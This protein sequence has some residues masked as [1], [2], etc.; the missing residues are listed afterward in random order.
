MPLLLA[1]ARWPGILDDYR[2]DREKEKQDLNV[3]QV[4]SDGARPSIEYYVLTV[5]SC[6]IATAGLITGSTAVIIGAMIVAPLMTP[7]LAFS[8]AVV[9]GDLALVRGSLFSLARGVVLAVGISALISVLVPIA[10]PS[11]EIIS[12]T[13]PTLY[14]IIVALVAGVLGAY[15][16]ANRK[17]NSAVVGIAI[18][19]AL[20]PPLCTV[21]IELGKG[22]YSSAA[23]ASLLFAINLVSISLA[24]SVVFLVMKI[25]PRSEADGGAKRRALYQIVLS[26]AVLVAI[27]IPV[28]AYVRTGYILEQSRQAAA[29]ILTATLPGSRVFSSEALAQGSAYVLRLTI[30]GTH[31]PQPAQLLQARAEIRSQ[32]PLFERTDI[33]FLKAVELPEGS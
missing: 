9:W 21:G 24:G 26:A 5:L 30:V 20:M 18:A 17:I 12:R 6:I 33:T 16:Y 32:C 14:D 10:A 23:G 11:A 7:I 1:P 2:R 8:L 15:G 13:H 3:Y 28:A 22:A 4:L 31:D 25:H 27:A 29:R 19:V